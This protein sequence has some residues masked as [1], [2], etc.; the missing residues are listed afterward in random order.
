MP[1]AAQP[2]GMPEMRN[3]EVPPL[4]D[5]SPLA[6]L[7]GL[8]PQAFAMAAATNSPASLAL[9]KFEL[10]ALKFPDSSGEQPLAAR[11][12]HPAEG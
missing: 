8:Y 2:A 9:Q 12:P 11:R 3:S 10:T 1:E 6:S 5:E 7:A 4:N